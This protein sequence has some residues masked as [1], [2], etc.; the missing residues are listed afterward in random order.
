MMSTHAVW[1]C[2]T[3]CASSCA[4]FGSVRPSSELAGN[5]GVEEP[6]VSESLARS[7]PSCGASSSH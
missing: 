2:S 5:I 7:A 1:S 3:R 6:S 4:C